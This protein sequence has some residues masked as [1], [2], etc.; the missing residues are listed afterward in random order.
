SFS[1]SSGIPVLE[2]CPV[3]RGGGV[4]FSKPL[5]SRPLRPIAPGRLMGSLLIRLGGL[6]ALLFLIPLVGRLLWLV[7]GGIWNGICGPPVAP[8]PANR[9]RRRRTCPACGYTLLPTD[10]DCYRCGLEQDSRLAAQVERIRSAEREV[11]AL[12][13]RGE[14]DPETAGQVAARLDARVRN[15]TRRPAAVPEATPLPRAVPV[16]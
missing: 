6:I 16:T 2:R 14:L 7:G 4:C 8:P 13:E 12:A 11:N 1:L 9:P 15:L 3:L 5:A 10:R